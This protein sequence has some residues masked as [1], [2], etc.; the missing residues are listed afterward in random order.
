MAYRPPSSL[1]AKVF[2]KRF[3]VGVSSSFTMPNVLTPEFN[4]YEII[5][6]AFTPQTNVKNPSMRFSYN[7]GSS[8]ISSGYLNGALI[9]TSQNATT[10]S[11][12]TSTTDPRLQGTAPNSTAL[13]GGCFYLRLLNTQG[14][15]SALSF[16]LIAA[17]VSAVRYGRSITT[18]L[19]DTAVNALRFAA[20][21]S[22]NITRMFVLVYGLRE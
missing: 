17:N 22:S 18:Y 2:L 5:I 7:N 9:Q 14:F 11:T 20:V 13:A 8:Y 6:Y 16:G 12:A 1:P 4:N 21:A 10:L 15:T 3:N 19:S